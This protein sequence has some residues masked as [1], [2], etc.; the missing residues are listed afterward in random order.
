MM[1]GMKFS[2][3]VGSADAHLSND[4]AVAKMGHMDLLLRKGFL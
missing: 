3:K 1:V 4:E 2:G